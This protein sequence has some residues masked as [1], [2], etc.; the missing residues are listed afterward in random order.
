MGSKVPVVI[1]V[2]DEKIEQSMAEEAKKRDRFDSM[3]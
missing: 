1:E 2:K 3:S